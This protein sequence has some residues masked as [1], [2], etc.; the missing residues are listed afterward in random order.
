MCLYL[1]YNISLLQTQPSI[2][3]TQGKGVKCA[4][5]PIQKEQD[6]TLPVIEM[7]SSQG[8]LLTLNTGQHCTDLKSAFFSLAHCFSFKS[9]PKE[10][11]ETQ[12][13]PPDWRFYPL[14]APVCTKCQPNLARQ[15]II[16]LTQASLSGPEAIIFWWGGHFSGIL[17]S[18]SVLSGNP[19]HH[20]SR[21]G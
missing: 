6:R 16:C 17:L 20:Y 7:I 4:H 9:L 1:Q 18:A 2:V 12:S 15:P 8:R 21:C 11:R 5:F 10:S 14:P 3:P 19:V 13:L